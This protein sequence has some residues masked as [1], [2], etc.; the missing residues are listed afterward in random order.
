VARRGSI[1]ASDSDRELVVEHLR[2]AAAEG[3]IAA[4]ELEE[5]VGT[6]LSART[7]GELDATVADLPGRG[8]QRSRSHRAIATVRS[9]PALLLAAI[10]VV[11]LAVAVMLALT[12]TWIVLM[13]LLFLLGR[14][15]ALLLS[16]GGYP[17][18]RY[19][20]GRGRRRL[21]GYWV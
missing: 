14:R 19:G 9:H 20:P 5:R 15:H 6:A 10:P 11:V 12:V 2:S 16:R 4:H 3:R 21:P 8:G 13:A 1:R 7:Y 17:P 18:W